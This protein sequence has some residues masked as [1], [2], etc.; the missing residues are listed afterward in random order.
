MLRKGNEMDSSR[1]VLL[2]TTDNDVIVQVERIT[3]TRGPI[4]VAC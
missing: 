2:G 3:S 4:V 1:G